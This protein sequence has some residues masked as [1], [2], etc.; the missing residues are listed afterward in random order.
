MTESVKQQGNAVPITSFLFL[1]A[2]GLKGENP[3]LTTKIASIFIVSKAA[4]WIN[5]DFTGDIYI[6]SNHPWE[7]PSTNHRSAVD[8][9]I[10]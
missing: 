1:Q 7:F 4:E 5:Y 9:G 10:A 6:Y 3:V 8:T 2:V